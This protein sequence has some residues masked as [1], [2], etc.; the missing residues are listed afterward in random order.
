MKQVMYIFRSL[1]QIKKYMLLLL[2]LNLE[3]LQ[4]VERGNF[5]LKLRK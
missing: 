3:M 5:Q 4:L 1:D 2:S